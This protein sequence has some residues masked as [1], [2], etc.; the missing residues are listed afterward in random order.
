MRTSTRWRTQ[1]RADNAYHNVTT[2]RLDMA[3]KVQTSTIDVSKVKSREHTA[4]TYLS[5]PKHKLLYMLT[6][7]HS[8]T[9]NNWTNSA[10]TNLP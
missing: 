7:P 4:R 1:Y 3:Q 9:R 10:L 2:S 5:I 8:S 6:A